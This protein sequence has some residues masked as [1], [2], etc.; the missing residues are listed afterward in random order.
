MNTL[1]TNFLQYLLEIR[2]VVYI[3]RLRVINSW[4]GW[5]VIEG[6]IINVDIWSHEGVG[7]H[8]LAVFD[9]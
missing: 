3:T 9:N 1:N 8:L 7:T 4:D 5:S 2:N 6:T